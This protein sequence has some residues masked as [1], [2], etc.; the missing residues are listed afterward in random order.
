MLDKCNIRIPLNRVCVSRYAIAG[1]ITGTNVQLNFPGK[2]PKRL[3]LAF[4][5][6]AAVS[7][8]FGQNPFN[9]QHFGL[10]NLKVTVSKIQYRLMVWK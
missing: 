6:N 5:T 8:A 9:F 3:F 2:R 10:T 1:G 7:G 4:A